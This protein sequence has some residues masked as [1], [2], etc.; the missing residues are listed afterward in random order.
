MGLGR[1]AKN[2][3]PQTFH[4]EL[5]AGGRAAKAYLPGTLVVECSE[6]NADKSLPERFAAE[7]VFSECRI[8]SYNVCYTK[9]LRP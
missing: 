4:G 5:P 1:E 7:A 9:L 6:Y 3:L 8:T 2:V